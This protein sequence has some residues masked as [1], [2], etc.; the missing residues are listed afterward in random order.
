M[1]RDWIPEE[2]WCDLRQGQEVYLFSSALRL[3][4]QLFKPPIQW[5]PEG[6]SPGLKLTTLPLLWRRWLRHCATSRK[7]A[8]S[9]PDGVI[10]IFN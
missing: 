5:V 8:G 6:L 3:V 7:F 4:M 9:I 10:G 2:S 1:S